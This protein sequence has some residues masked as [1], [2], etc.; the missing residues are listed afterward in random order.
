MDAE[1]EGRMREINTN[2][3]KTYGFQ[4]YTRQQVNRVTWRLYTA[5]TKSTE[6]AE[7]ERLMY[8]KKPAS[9][10]FVC[11]KAK[12]AYYAGSNHG[13]V[14]SHEKQEISSKELQKLIQRLQ[15]PT[16]SYTI[17]CAPKDVPAYPRVKSS[18]S[19]GCGRQVG[20]ELGK[21]PHRLTQHTVSSASKRLGACLFCDGPKVNKSKYLET[22]YDQ[23]QPAKR[24]TADQL[25]KHVERL[26]TPT[27]SST[28]A[29]VNKAR[30]D[31]S[32]YTCNEPLHGRDVPLI[33]GLP[34]SRDI[35]E[36][37]VRLTSHKKSELTSNL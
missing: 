20:T 10:N 5:R 24:M 28:Y 6:T 34:R 30:A 4:I 9:H 11:A 31:N 37:V 13:A 25:L 23:R 15:R 2:S 16:S 29:R 19:L 14:S 33:S 22:W 17:S 36:I 21:T 1:S 12:N 32:D 8:L 3:S 35:E 7:R 18:H 27:V 26:S